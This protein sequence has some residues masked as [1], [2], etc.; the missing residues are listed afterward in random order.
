MRLPLLLP[1]LLA[2]CQAAEKPDWAKE[3]APGA[4]LPAEACAKI[5]QG[6]GSLAKAGFDYDDKGGAT[7]MTAA[8]LD[9]PPV[10][11]DQLATT[12]AY[13]AACAAG[14]TSDAQTVIIR[15]DD[16]SELLRRTLSTKV[17]PGDLFGGE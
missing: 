17:D 11:R 14:R 2:A 7:V 3:G 8:W 13:H 6:L 16:G 12:L 9:M 10:R 15:G 5:K 4:A 1:L